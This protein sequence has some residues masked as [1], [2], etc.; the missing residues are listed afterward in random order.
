MS[1]LLILV[2]SIFVAAPL[3]CFNQ[4]AAQTQKTSTQ[5]TAPQLATPAAAVPAP[6]SSMAGLPPSISLSPSVVMTKG[7]Y[8]QGLTQTLTLTNSTGVEFAFEMEAQDVVIRDGKRVFVAAGETENSIAATAVFSQKLVI[9]K[10]YSSASVDVRLTLP[11]QTRIRAVVAIFRGTN[12]LPTSSSAVG[13]TASLGTLITFNLSDNVKLEPE[14]VRIVPA[15]ETSNLTVAQWITNTGTE[16]V[17]ADGMAV[18]LKASGSLVG[19]VPLPQQRLLPGERLEFT[20][21]Y[22]EQLQPGDYK[23]MCSL[24]F[25]GKALTS[26]AAFKIQ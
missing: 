15:T 25:E 16:P 2:A 13:M 17:L 22:P 8:G 26:D 1:R 12:K 18:F 14:V 20:A 4:A 10:P 21:E 5:K 6:P 9:A 3:C 23:A 7:S 11:P 24:Q 19:K